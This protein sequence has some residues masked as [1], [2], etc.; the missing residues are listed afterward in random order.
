MT[1][2]K[3]VKE[4]YLWDFLGFRSGVDEA[5]VLLRYDTTSLVICLPT[6]RDAVS[7]LSSTVFFFAVRQLLSRNVGKQIID[8]AISYSRKTDT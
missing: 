8:D 4:K 6:F 3:T 7:A 2:L 5:A 1:S